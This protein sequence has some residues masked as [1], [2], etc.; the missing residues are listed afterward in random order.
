MG[1]VNWREVEQ[2]R[3]GGKQLGRCL[4]FLVSGAT[5]EEKKKKK[6]EE[7]E[8]QKKEEEQKEEEDIIQMINITV[9]MHRAFTENG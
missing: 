7:E 2:D 8:E 4:S 9:T 5:E 6:K 3:G 1:T